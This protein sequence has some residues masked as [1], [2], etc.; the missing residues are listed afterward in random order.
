VK[1]GT[2]LSREMKFV[3]AVEMTYESKPHSTLKT[4]SMLDVDRILGSIADY[5]LAS[6]STGSTYPSRRTQVVAATGSKRPNIK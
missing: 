1:P 3:C 2:A 5:E 4:P 6:R